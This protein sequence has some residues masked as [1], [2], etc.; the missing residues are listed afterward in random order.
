MI[1]PETVLDTWK[2]TR[3]DAAQAVEDLPDGDLAFRPLPELMTFG[4]IARHIL[5]AGHALSGMLLEGVENFQVP[6]FR[7]MV[8]KRDFPLPEDADASE[9]AA[10][11]RQS[12]DQRTAELSRQSPEFFAKIVT[13]WDGAKLTRLELIQFLKEHEL[14]HRAQLFTYLR[15]KGVTPVTT[16]RRQSKQA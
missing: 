15:F 8:K 5:G 9:L 6:E 14:G 4:E 10:A 2:T 3:A 16:R 13:K 11:M 1:R 7:E 12:V